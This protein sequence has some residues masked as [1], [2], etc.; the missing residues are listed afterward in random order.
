MKLRYG[1]VGMAAAFLSVCGCSR[2][3]PLMA[4]ENAKGILLIQSEFS[5][6]DQIICVL[7]DRNNACTARSAQVVVR[8]LSGM[9]QLLAE[10]TAEDV[11]SVYV[12]GGKVTRCQPSAARG[13]VAVEVW[14]VPE[15]APK[16][17]VMPSAEEVKAAG[18]SE[19]CSGRGGA[20]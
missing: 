18:A 1:M 4:K 12:R 6:S 3:D 8:G 5:N 7:E 15:N 9:D 17:K 13:Q 20:D 19:L 10:W 2:Y 14:Q 11:V 16:I